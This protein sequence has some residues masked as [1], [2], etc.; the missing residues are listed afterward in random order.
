MRLQESGEMYLETLLLLS[1]EH[2]E[3]RA[4]D[5][6]ERMGYTKPSV[7]R[8]IGLLKHMGHVVTDAD[9][10][11]HLTPT[12]LAIAEKT[13]E[14]HT[15]LTQV[16]MALGVSEKTAADDACK[17]EHVISDETFNAIKSHLSQ[18]K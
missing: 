9:G 10:F 1:R 2:P 17:I 6:G 5:L 12:G 14:R 11:L 3:V 16:F 18:T 13:Y 4:V 7:S 8:A 15:V